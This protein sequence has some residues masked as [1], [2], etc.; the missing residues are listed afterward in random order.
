MPFIFGNVWIL[1]SLAEIV[2][3]S[4][5]LNL[6][7]KKDLHSIFYAYSELPETSLICNLWVDFAL[8]ARKHGCELRSSM[9]G[10]LP[11][12]KPLSGIVWVVVGK[13]VANLTESLPVICNDPP[14][15]AQVTRLILV[16][17]TS[18]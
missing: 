18:D 2:F 9:D 16:P 11:A 10:G 3:N 7:S 12:L 4:H 14:V 5:C 1:A 8:E 6:I 13:L 15:S 17:Q